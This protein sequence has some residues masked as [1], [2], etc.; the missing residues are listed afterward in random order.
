M[1]RVDV[2]A[3]RREQILAAAERLLAR[4]GWARTTFADICKEAGISNGVLTYHFKDKD[5]ILLA[6]LEKVSRTSSDRFFSLL[7]EQPSWPGKLDLIVH[8]NLSSTAEEREM[9]MLNLHLLSLAAQRP[10]IAQRL[11]Q[12]YAFSMQ[13]A[14]AEIEQAIEQG[15]IKRHD[16]AAVAAVIQMLVIGMSFGSLILDLTVPT[17]QLMDEVL[18]LLRCYLGTDVEEQKQK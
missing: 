1:G 9:S 7:Q 15:Q 5:E 14:Q 17:E 8:S 12:T 4:N 11:R 3:I 18:A 6:V 2:H 13:R 10:E 16:S